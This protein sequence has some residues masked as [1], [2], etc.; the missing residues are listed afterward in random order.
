MHLFM[1]LTQK[2]DTQIHIYPKKVVRSL[3]Y[4]FLIKIET[5]HLVLKRSQYT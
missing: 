3:N 5:N 1:G 4:N 2:I